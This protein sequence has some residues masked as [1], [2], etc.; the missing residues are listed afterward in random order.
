MSTSVSTDFYVSGGELVGLEQRRR[1]APAGLTGCAPGHK[2]SAHTGHWTP[3]RLGGTDGH[4]ERRTSHPTVLWHPSPAYARAPGPFLSVSARSRRTPPTPWSWSS[5]N[6]SP[7]PC[8]TAAAPTPWTWSRPGQHR[9][10]RARPLLPG[11][12]HAH[13]RSEQRRRLRPAH[14]QPPRPRHR[15]H[16]PP[17]GEQDPERP[18]AAV[19]TRRKRRAAL[20]A[21]AGESDRS[22]KVLTSRCPSCQHQVLRRDGISARAAGPTSKP[23]MPNGLTSLPL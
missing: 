3:Q 10:G 20:L 12:P 17:V 2:H 16:P 21:V 9:G 22:G 23:R 15:R 11:A 5:P 14:G 18:P 8:A 13:P 1:K 4:D 6:S 7:T 19:A